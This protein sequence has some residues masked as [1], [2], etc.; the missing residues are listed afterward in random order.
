MDVT[1]GQ[2][3]SRGR[4]EQIF[5]LSLPRSGSTLVRLL[6]DTHSAIACPG[7]LSL[8][9]LSEA[10]HHTLSYSLGQADARSDVERDAWALREARAAIERI[11][12]PYAAAKGK[13]LWAEKTPANLDHAET[14]FRVFPRAAFICLHR[15][16]L[17]TIRSG[18]ESSRFGRLK[19]DLWDYRSSCEFYV[20]QTRKLLA[21][22]GRHPA[23]CFRLSYEALV[24]QPAATADGLFEFLGLPGEPGLLDTIFST[25]H[26]RGPGDPKAEFATAIYT[27]SIGRGADISS[28]VEGLPASLRRAIADLATDLGYEPISATGA[29][30][31][32]ATPRPRPA[33]P[34]PM[35]VPS[36]EELFRSFVPLRLEQSGAILAPLKGTVKFQVKGAGGGTWTIDLDRTP[37][38]VAAADACADCVIAI[39]ADDLL[40]LAS[41]EL[42]VGECYLQAKLRL[43]GNEALAVSIGRALFA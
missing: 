6:L 4:W 29:A 42:N 3:R 23:S 30:C 41:G 28:I 34:G 19:Y 11:M 25:P 32:G 22:E 5:V 13:P 16:P 1:V 38:R 12:A 24:R 33:P 27:S 2:D 40:K 7:E 36:V 9:R 35:R 20:D 10:L 37:P 15:D 17:D 39:R 21:F 8:G 14:L 26:E 43:Q 18:I 31:L